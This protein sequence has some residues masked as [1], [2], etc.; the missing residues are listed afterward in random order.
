M[1]V[2][3]SKT[4]QV[5]EHQVEVLHSKKSRV[6][7]RLGISGLGDLTKESYSGK[8]SGSASQQN[9]A[10]KGTSSG[11]A[12]QEKYTKYKGSDLGGRPARKLLKFSVLLAYDRHVV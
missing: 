1:E 11:S 2:L 7:H 9:V 3:Q 5:R 6:H 12:S 4:P 8:S 10:G